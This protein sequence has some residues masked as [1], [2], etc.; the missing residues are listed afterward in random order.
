MQLVILLNAGKE[1]K[2]L[3][4]CS[5]NIL[6]L[7]DP[8]RPNTFQRQTDPFSLFLSTSPPRTYIPKP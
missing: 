8:F 6:S 3:Q 4:D 1:K 2:P 7:T 5:F